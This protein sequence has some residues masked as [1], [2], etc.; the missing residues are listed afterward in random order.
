VND[1]TFAANGVIAAALN[2]TALRP[3]E[4]LLAITSPRFSTALRAR[5]RAVRAWDCW[6]NSAYGDNA[7]RA[8]LSLRVRLMSS[9]FI[10]GR[11]MQL[12]VLA[13]VYGSGQAGKSQQRWSIW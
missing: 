1:Q 2:V 8:H 10:E 3:L 13:V 11:T 12:R 4:F 5:A 9:D 7:W 6:L